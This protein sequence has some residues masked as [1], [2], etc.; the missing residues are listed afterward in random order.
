MTEFVTHPGSFVFDPFRSREPAE[1]LL[2]GC[3][4]LLGRCSE[5][6]TQQYIMI[7]T[8]FFFFLV[9]RCGLAVRRLA[10]KQKDLGTIRFGSPFSS[11]KCG[12]WTLSCEFA[13]TIN[14][15]LK[16]LTQLPTLM[17]NHSGGDGVTSR[18]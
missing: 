15:T 16:W 3:A 4:V 1:L 9:R 13:H 11:K 18:C 5:H 17:Q 10:G 6:N 14:E 2:K 8:G 12:L 7:L